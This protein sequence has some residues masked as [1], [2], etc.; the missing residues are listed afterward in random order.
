MKTNAEEEEIL[1]EHR[2]ILISS[3]TLQ[4]GT[5]I[6]PQLLFHLKLGLVVKKHT[7]LLST[8]QRNVSTAFYRQ[9]WTPEGKVREI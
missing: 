4:N 5:L 7:V 3:F 6:T 8:P 2:K 9:Q 1:S